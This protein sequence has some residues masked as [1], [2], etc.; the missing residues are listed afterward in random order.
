MPDVGEAVGEQQAAIDAA[1][2]EVA[3]DLLAAAQPALAEV[4]AAACLDRAQAIDGAASCLA[5]RRRRLDHDV[6]DVVV[7][8]DAE[9]VVRLEAGDRLLDGALGDP[10]L[11]P[12]HRPRAVEDDS[13]VDGWP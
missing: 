6:D 8:D 12:G 7:H 10:Q 13:Q 11:L 5:R 1:I 2:D 9:P 4:R 3:G